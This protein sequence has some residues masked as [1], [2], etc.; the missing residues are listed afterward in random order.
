MHIKIN[1]LGVS[2]MSLRLILFVRFRLA[3]MVFRLFAS[4]TESLDNMSQ[5]MVCTFVPCLLFT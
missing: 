2:S 4:A 5:E 3:W 1:I